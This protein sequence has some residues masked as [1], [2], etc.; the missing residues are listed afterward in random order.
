MPNILRFRSRFGGCLE[1]GAHFRPQGGPR[2]SRSV[3]LFWWPDS[4][5]Q[6]LPRMPQ[7]APAGSRRP[8]EAT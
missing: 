6:I 1:R 3:C 2:L 7:E 4:W 5:A 8:Q